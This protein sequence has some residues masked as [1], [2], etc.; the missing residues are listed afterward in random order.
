MI[1][2][3]SVQDDALGRESV[4][5]GR[6]DRVGVGKCTRGVG[7]ETRVVVAKIVRKD[8]HEMRLRCGH[9]EEAQKR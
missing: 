5:S 1:G 6:S 4:E 8:V 9:W 7:I 2:I 3:I